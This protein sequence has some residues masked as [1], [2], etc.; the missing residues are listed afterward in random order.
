[1]ADRVELYKRLCAGAEFNRK[2]LNQ[3]ME[4]IH[5]R[6]ALNY[7]PVPAHAPVHGALTRNL[8]G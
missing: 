2:Q 7:A 5:V 8:A 4:A 1:M 6:C 3:D